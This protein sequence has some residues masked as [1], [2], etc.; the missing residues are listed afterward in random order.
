MLLLR[1]VQMLGL[2]L[3]FVF[4][5]TVRVIPLTLPTSLCESCVCP[6]LDPREQFSS[7]HAVEYRRQT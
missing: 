2:D 4:G 6:F 1:T 5:I 7:L 3:E